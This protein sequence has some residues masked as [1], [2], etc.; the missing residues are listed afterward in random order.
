MSTI[1]EGIEDARHLEAVMAF[2]CE[3]GQGYHFSKP[4]SAVLATELIANSRRPIPT[5][6]AAE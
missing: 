3:Y 4:L 1:A 5:V 6:I 2:G